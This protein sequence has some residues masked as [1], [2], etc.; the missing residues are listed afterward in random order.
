MKKS[1]KD[2]L[3]NSHLKDESKTLLLIRHAKSSWDNPSLSDFERPLNERGKNDAPL[4]AKK[5]KEKK[6]KIDVF[7]TSP[8]KRARQTCKY[9]AKEFDFKK[10]DIVTEPELYEAGEENFYR[11]IGG[12]KNKWDNVVIVSHNPGITSF[13][14]SLTETRIDDMPTCSVFAIKIATDKWANFRTAKK[15]FWFFDYPRIEAD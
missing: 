6:I 15:E 1:K 4:M 14:N 5:M 10:K 3:R 9:F 2:S 13:V 12:F 7:V 8:A 11:V